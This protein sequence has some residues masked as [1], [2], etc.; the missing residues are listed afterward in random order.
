[1]P[2]PRWIRLGFVDVFGTANSVLLPADRWDAAVD[3][4]IVF[5][6][7]ALEGRARV[8]ESEMLLRP[9]PSTLVDLGDGT[10]RALCAVLT[11]AGAPWL[12]DPR[13]ALAD[14]VARTAE[15][16]SVWSASAELECYVLTPSGEPIDRGFYFDDADGPGAAIV[17]GAADVVADH[18][19]PVSSCHH[20]AGPGQYEIDLGPLGPEALADALVATK[21]A[22]REQAGAAG[23]AVSFMP[24]PFDGEAGSGLHLHQCIDDLAFDAG[25]ALSADGRAVIGGLLAHSTGLCAVAT[26]TVNSYKRLHGTDEAPGAVMWS[27]RHRAALV[28]VSPKGIEY[29]GADPSANPYLLVAGLLLAGADGLESNLDPGP[30]QDESLGG[31][32]GA[33]TTVRA[34]ILP[35][36]LDEALDAFLADDVLLDGFDGVLVQRLVDGRRAEAAAYGR[37]VT[38]WERERYLFE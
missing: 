1:M 28:R 3:H 23:L 34:R 6:G 33:A 27:H 21:Q 37:H 4:G 15:Y 2:A 32:E 9:V 7:S 16:A 24:R 36:T 35:R 25:G 14:V 38:S 8:F 30:P 12:G 5:D 17:R 22:V 10:A 11:P 31:F 20:E 18:G 13:T 26:P 19:I 29:R